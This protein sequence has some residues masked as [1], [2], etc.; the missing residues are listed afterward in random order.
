MRSCLPTRP[1]APVVGV[2]YD[3]KVEQ[4]MDLAGLP[5]RIPLHSFSAERAL[6]AIETLVPGLRGQVHHNDTT[7]LV[8]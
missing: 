5:V 4:Y 1:G 2:I 6:Q 7:P 3:D 8:P